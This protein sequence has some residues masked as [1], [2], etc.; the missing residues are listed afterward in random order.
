MI[1]L[2]ILSISNSK[3]ISNI[4]NLTKVRHINPVEADQVN[5]K[6]IT[7]D[8]EMNFDNCDIL[9]NTKNENRKQ[10]ALKFIE[11]LKEDK[12]S[13]F[14]SN[15]EVSFIQPIEFESRRKKQNNI[16]E[17]HD[18]PFD[19]FDLN[20]YLNIESRRRKPVM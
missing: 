5:N 14:H 9:K 2:K 1:A 11:D 8:D 4:M 3:S 12:N 18:N 13:K 19:T 20:D 15:K 16:I 17:T 7:L 6:I 10:S